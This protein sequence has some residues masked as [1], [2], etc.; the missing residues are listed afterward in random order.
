M[1]QLGNSH[2]RSVP[3]DLEYTRLEFIESHVG[4]GK[5]M[6]GIVFSSILQVELIQGLITAQIQFLVAAQDT[7]T[8]DVK[9]ALSH[10]KPCCSNYLLSGLVAQTAEIKQSFQGEEV[11]LKIQLPQ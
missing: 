8:E 11:N 7:Q 9:S 1:C 6:K 10:P 4:L 2:Y 5:K 3:A